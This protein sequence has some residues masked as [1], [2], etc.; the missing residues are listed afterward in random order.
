MNLYSKAFYILNVQNFFFHGKIYPKLRNL[1]VGLRVWSREKFL[2][3][4]INKKKLRQ[5]KKSERL[6]DQG[7]YISA[8]AV[9]LSV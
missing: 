9:G 6:K 7:C 5:V 4:K 1:Q 2:V 3:K 8:N